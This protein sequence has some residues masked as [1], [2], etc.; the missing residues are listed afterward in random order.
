[1]QTLSYRQARWLVLALGTAIL[2]AVTASASLRGADPVE[3]GA[4]ALFIP[5]TV[6][7][8]LGGPLWGGIAGSAAAIGY[9]I[10]RL[11]TLAGADAG[12]FAGSIIARVLL[13]VSFGVLG[14]IANRNLEQSLKKLEIY[15]EVDDL[16]DVGNARSLLSLADREAARA[17]RYQTTFSLGLI[18]LDASTLAGLSTRQSDKVIRK[19]YGEV[20]RA[21]RTTDKVTRMATDTHE[22]LAIVLPETGPEGARIFVER[23]RA[24]LAST[25]AEMD[26]TVDETTLVGEWMTLPGDEE[27]LKAHLAKVREFTAKMGVTT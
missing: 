11:S 14:G 18:R 3:V 4:I 13:F 9:T 21:I 2:L 10:V 17:Q 22:E 23:A 6:M 16:T 27:R 1:M 24:G 5:V 12:E 25:L 19:F 20:D 8:V 7:L 26:V 15:D